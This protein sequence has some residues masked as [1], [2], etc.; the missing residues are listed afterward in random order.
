MPTVHAQFLERSGLRHLLGGRCH[1]GRP[2]RGKSARSWRPVVMR[3]A[4]VS[5]W[6]SR[7]AS[8]R[9]GVLDCVLRSRAR[10]RRCVCWLAGRQR[11]PGRMAATMKARLDQLKLLEESSGR[12]AATA[13][14]GVEAAVRI[15]RPQVR[16]RSGFR[17]AAQLSHNKIAV[18]GPSSSASR[19][20]PAPCMCCAP[21]FAARPE[22]PAR[23]AGGR[24]GRLYRRCRRTRQQPA[25]QRAG[26]HQPGGH[27]PQRPV[28]HRHGE[29][30]QLTALAAVGRPAADAGGMH[31]PSALTHPSSPATNATV[32]SAG[33]RVRCHHVGV[34]ALLH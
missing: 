19:S 13:V 26:D 16:S 31:Q 23:G 12:V 30:T 11:A 32:S 33:P 22:C 10:R 7:I 1:G 20:R 2:C 9:W 6:T 15:P 34:P 21:H 24:G 4:R 27:G 17:F 3:G 29:D 5:Q 18:A 25:Q 14:R 28:P 8:D